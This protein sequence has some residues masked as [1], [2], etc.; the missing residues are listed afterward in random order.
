MRCEADIQKYNSMIQ[1]DRVYTFMDG[2]DDR[3]DKIRADVLQLQ[4]FPTV[5]QAY[6]HV[7]REDLR[8]T[9]ML[10][11]EE[12]ISSMVMVSKGGQ[13]SQQ[14]PSLQI[15]KP[16]TLTK[17]KNQADVGGC[18]H[19]GNQKHTKD[20][21]FKLHGYPDWWHEL[22][23]KKKR[24]GGRAALVNAESSAPTE[25][26]LSLVPENGPSLAAANCSFTNNESGNLNWIID[27]GA[28]DHMTFDPQDFIETTQPRQTH[29]TNANGVKYPVT[30]A[31]T[32][33]FSPALSL[34]N[35]LLVPALL[36]KLLSVGQAT[37]ELNCCALIYPKFCL[38]QDILTKEIIGRDKNQNNWENWPCFQENIETLRVENVEMP[39]AIRD[40]KSDEKKNDQEQEQH[41]LDL[42]PID[43]PPENNPEA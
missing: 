23:A 4:P 38:F 43:Q 30:G 6:S 15:I 29:I 21:C 3:L 11:K 8:Q 31:G 25:P 28:T 18:T 39:P 12:T 17:Q 34:S 14:Q 35:T 1:E 22:K 42:V 32:V 36:N 41:P 26:H 9:V 13:K 5:E 24:D 27:S 37:E 2:L 33:A 10:A 20:T 16:S 19:C 40:R 7:R